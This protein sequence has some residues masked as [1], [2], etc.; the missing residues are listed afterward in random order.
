MNE[1][2]IV[3]ASATTASRVKKHLVKEKYYAKVIQTPKNLSDGGCS[4]CVH[5][6]FD[7]LEASK[8]YAKLLDVKIKAVYKKTDSGFVKLQ[9]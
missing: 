7:A 5:T 2:I 1:I 9:R 8:S 4:Y 3:F 6:T